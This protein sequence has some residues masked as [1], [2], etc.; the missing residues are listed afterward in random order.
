MRGK[1]SCWKTCTVP[2]SEPW[3]AAPRCCGRNRGPQTR[4][5]R[6]VGPQRPSV[7]SPQSPVGNIGRELFHAARGRRHCV[8]HAPPVASRR[9]RKPIVR[10]RQSLAGEGLQVLV[11][12]PDQPD[13]FARICGYFD[14]AGFILDARYIPPTTITRWIHSRSVASSQPG[15][16]RELT[17]MVESDLVRAIE[18]GGPCPSPL[19]KGCRGASKLSP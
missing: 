1:A 18:A 15:H 12:A 10:A 19:A 3:A 9:H 14:R 17:H 13:L 8:A 11:Y 7:R 16:Y 6:A 2:P 4:S 5:A